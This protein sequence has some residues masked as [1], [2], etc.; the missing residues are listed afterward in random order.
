VLGLLDASAPFRRSLVEL[1]GSGRR[2][3]R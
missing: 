3:L 2:A 1:I